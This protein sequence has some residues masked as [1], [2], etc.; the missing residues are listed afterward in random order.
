MSSTNAK[1]CP[2]L[3]KRS[4]SRQIV[5]WYLCF[6]SSDFQHTDLYR[7]EDHLSGAQER[8]E[9]DRPDKET[10]VLDTIGIESVTLDDSR[11]TIIPVE[12]SPSLEHGATLVGRSSLP[13]FVTS[14]L[15]YTANFGKEREGQGQLRS[16][17]QKH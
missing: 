9:R 16:F 10:Y 2:P 5:K 4:K 1:I 15:I 11:L 13:A 14:T 12:S 3:W 8:P 17:K 7:L 6:T